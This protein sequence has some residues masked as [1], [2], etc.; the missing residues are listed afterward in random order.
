MRKLIVTTF[1]TLD[2]VMEAPGAEK[3][4]PH[5]GW[6]GPFFDAEVGKYKLQETLDAESLLIGRVT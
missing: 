2:G 6:V 5:A 4:H 3:T 1:L